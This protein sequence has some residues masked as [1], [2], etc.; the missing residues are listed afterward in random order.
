[1]LNA[2]SC[3]ELVLSPGIIVASD[4]RQLRYIPSQAVGSVLCFVAD[5]AS[6]HIVKHCML[7]DFSKLD[8]SIH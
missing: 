4:D 2:E 6:Q 7:F 1:M 3:A 5:T 8:D